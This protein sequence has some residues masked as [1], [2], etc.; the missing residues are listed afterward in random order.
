MPKV[1]DK[2]SQ[3]WPATAAGPP[4]GSA[5]SIEAA[6]ESRPPGRFPDGR[7]HRTAAAEDPELRAT[8]TTDAAKLADQVQSTL[9]REVHRT[10]ILSA[11]ADLVAERGLESVTVRQLVTRAS[12]SPSESISP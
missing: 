3:L 1:A 8:A 12:A 9:A 10:W 7:A 4:A 11:M 5:G 2:G 6:G